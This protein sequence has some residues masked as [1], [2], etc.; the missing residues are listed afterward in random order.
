MRIILLC[1]LFV[2]A[3]LSAQGR[4]DYLYCNIQYPVV[5]MLPFVGPEV[6]IDANQKALIPWRLRQKRPGEFK[7]FAKTLFEDDLMHLVTTDTFFVFSPEIGV[8]QDIVV[9]SIDHGDLSSD[10]FW[11]KRIKG[12]QDMNADSLTTFE[13]CKKL[14]NAQLERKCYA[15]AL[16]T[17][18]AN[19]SRFDL[20][21][22]IYF[23]R[24]VDSIIREFGDV[25]YFVKDGHPVCKYVARDG[26]V[27][28]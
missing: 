25:E 12:L 23:F 24:E 8:E 4:H 15:S 26:T 28:R 18:E 19:K 17:C 6:L 27:H 14:I 16:Y 20:S 1:F 2:P 7:V 5:V 10:N 9:I 22:Y 13:E 11:L 21:E 3:L